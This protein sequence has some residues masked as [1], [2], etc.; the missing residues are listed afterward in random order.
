V[1]GRKQ[2][3]TSFDAS[4]PE[5]A[6]FLNRDDPAARAEIVSRYTPL[7]NR[8]AFRYRGRTEPIDDLKQVAA[9][10]LPHA[11]N[12]FDPERQVRFASFAAATMLGEL[13]R[14]LRDKA[15]SARVPRSLQEKWLEASRTAAD[16]AQSNG[17]S[18]TIAE[19]AR[20]MGVSAEDVLEA[21]DAGTAYNARSLDAP[22]GDEEG[23]A[24][25]LD[26]LPE[27]DE[28]LETAHERVTV[29]VHLREL[30]DRERL[31]LYLRF[32][33]GLTQSEIAERIGISQMHVSRLL[34]RSLGLLR[35]HLGEDPA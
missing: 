28:H 13:R 19:I 23:A 33:E 9:M 24:S 5:E 15:W 7:A 29:A 2:R 10:G 6:L 4:T 32:F 21:M 34:R 14:H 11:I 30:P 27:V 25:A 31:I 22:V 16:L 20:V 8:L 1:T 17:R 12:R 3:T 35:D 26:L 18:P